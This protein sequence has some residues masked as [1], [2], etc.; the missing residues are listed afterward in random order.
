MTHPAW[1]Y[2][3]FA[4]HFKNENEMGFGKVSEII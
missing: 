4:S 1:M 3:A 2:T